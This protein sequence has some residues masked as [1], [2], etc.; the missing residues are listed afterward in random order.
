MK[1][2]IN[3]NS[4]RLRLSKTDV[5]KLLAEGRVEDTVFFGPEQSACLT[6]AL[7]HEAASKLIDF[8]YGSQRAAVV[9]SSAEATR[10]ASGD[11]VGIYGEVDTGRGLLTLSV[12]KDFACLDQNDADNA[13]TF[14]N[15]KADK[16][17]Q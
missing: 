10:W 12:E 9:V 13:D 3:G 1:L 5:G 11:Q 15:P 7:E 6:Y 14:P 2:R 4:L 16:V 8:R 17:C